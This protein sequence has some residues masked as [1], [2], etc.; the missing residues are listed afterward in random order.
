MLVVKVVMRP[1]LATQHLTQIF[2]IF[3]SSST[4]VPLSCLLHRTSYCNDHRRSPRSPN[5]VYISPLEFISHW[6]SSVKTRYH[7]CGSRP[8]EPHHTVLT[9]LARENADWSHFTQA[10]PIR[11]YASRPLCRNKRGSIPLL[12]LSKRGPAQGIQICSATQ[13]KAR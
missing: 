8:M 9:Q 5:P 11:N 6:L 10:P 12:I 4:V 3:F 13:V 7:N 2:Y 1:Y